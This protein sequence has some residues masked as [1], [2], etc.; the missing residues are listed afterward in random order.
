MIHLVNVCFFLQLLPP[1]FLQLFWNRYFNL[2]GN[3]WKLNVYLIVYKER[4]TYCF[5]DIRVCFSQQITI[6]AE[7]HWHCCRMSRQI[8]RQIFLRFSVNQTMGESQWYHAFNANIFKHLAQSGEAF[9]S[10][11]TDAIQTMVKL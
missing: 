7:K 9:S 5:C 4:S 1:F 11:T 2:T 8:M 6:Y 3:F 10:W